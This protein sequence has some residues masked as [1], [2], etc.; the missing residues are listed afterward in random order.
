MALYLVT[1]TSTVAGVEPGGTVTL[2]PVAAQ[3]LIWGGHLTPAPKKPK[4]DEPKK[5]D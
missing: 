5:A 3:P 4:T 2:D 1:G